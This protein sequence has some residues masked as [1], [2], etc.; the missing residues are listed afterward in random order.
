MESSVTTN[1][2]ALQGKVLVFGGPYSNRQALEAM[3][4]VADDHAIAPSNT[5]C[6]G[7]VVGYCG[8]PE[9]CVTLIRDWGIHC[10]AGNV[11]KQLREGEEDCGCNFN[12]DSRCDT[13]SRQWYPFAQQQVSSSSL[14]W[15]H[16]LPDH[17]FFRYQ[18]KEGLVL[19]GS[20]FHVS[21]FIFRSTPWSIKEKNFKAADVDLIL[22][23]HCGIPFS[24]EQEGK[25]WLNAGVIG[26]PAN[27]G[28]PDVWYMILE[29]DEASQS[30]HYEYRPLA[31]DHRTAY[32][33]MQEAG[34]PMAYA[35]TL[36]DG[37]W[38][39][40]DILPAQETRE[41]GKALKDRLA[42]SNRS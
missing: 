38:D 3:K 5:I 24:Q 8:E 31:Y 7:D 18:G 1:I 12:S 6:T 21:D 15:M 25:L 40:C 27:D 23:G 26:M 34:L 17:I 32:Q 13:L 10:I 37:Y 4:E 35:Q 11:E 30:I 33:K 29:E 19:H 36:M 42:S 2:G 39:N 9:E 41:Q 16:T 28:T 14:A 20:Y 22:A